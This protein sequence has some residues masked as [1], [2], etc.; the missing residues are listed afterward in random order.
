MLTIVR[1]QQRARNWN[2]EVRAYVV[3]KPPVEVVR[4]VRTYHRQWSSRILG[5][6]KSFEIGL[7]VLSPGAR[8]GASVAPTRSNPLLA[9]VC[10]IEAEI[11]LPPLWKRNQGDV[12][13]DLTARHADAI[14]ITAVPGV[15]RPHALG[16]IE[17]GLCES[18]S[19]ATKH[20]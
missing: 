14:K 6:P 9:A 10:E 13:N 17:V 2:R 16:L 4:D 11:E 5:R 3:L 8:V 20:D 15:I 1:P 12:K 19:G 7:P 18:G